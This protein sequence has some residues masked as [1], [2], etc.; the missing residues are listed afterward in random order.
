[1]IS[2]EFLRKNP[3]IVQEGI[4]AKGILFDL[5]QFLKIDK[6]RL[7][8]LHFLEEKRREKNKWEKEF[9]EKKGKGELLAKM[10][11]IDREVDFLEK[12]FKEIDEK[13]QYLY[14]LIPNIPLPSVPRGKDERENVVLREVGEK[15]KFDFPPKSYLKIAEKLDLIDTKR[16]AKTSGT[17]FCF[18]KGK[19][20]SLQQALVNFVFDFLKKEGFL[21]LVVPVMIKPEMMWGMGYLQRPLADKKWEDP[22]TFFLRDDDLV[23]VATAEQ[24]IG[25]M[26]AQ[27]IFHEKELP[28]RYFALSP[29]F[30]REAGSYGKDTKGILRVHQF[31]KIEMFSFQKEEESEKEHSYFLSLEEKMMQSLNIPYRVLQICTGDLGMVAVAKYDIEAYFPSENKYRETHS[32]SNCTDFQS[33]RLKIRYKN[34]EGKIKY[35]HMVNGTAFAMGRILAAII[36]N[37]QNKQEDFDIPEVLKKYLI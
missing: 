6:E 33:R 10:R 19:L 21:P 7:S 13:W 15:K 12:K 1:M 8:L 2:L 14:S 32:T 34:R 31:D 37:Y 5:N 11:E 23:L 28:K 35:V 4:E 26:H 29:C 17:R 18:L 9:R 16:S 20:V 36:E 27:E 30:R 22:E 24:S 25:S 3:K